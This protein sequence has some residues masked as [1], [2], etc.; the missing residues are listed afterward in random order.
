MDAA[1]KMKN[2]SAAA[3]E[4]SGTAGNKRSSDDC[5]AADNTDCCAAA[6]KQQQQQDPTADSYAI[7][8]AD[9][10]AER[11]E[12]QA[13]QQAQGQQAP[14]AVQV[15]YAAVK[16]MDKTSKTPAG[17][18]WL[19]EFVSRMEI[20]ADGSFRLSGDK[21]QRAFDYDKGDWSGARNPCDFLEASLADKGKS[22][23]DEAVH[24]AARMEAARLHFEDKGRRWAHRGTS[25]NGKWYRG[26]PVGCS[27]SWSY[28]DAPFAPALG[29]SA[30]D[31][32]WTETKVDTDRWALD[33]QGKLVPQAAAAAGEDGASAAGAAGQAPTT[34]VMPVGCYLLLGNQVATRLEEKKNTYFVHL[35]GY[36]HYLGPQY[37]KE[38]RDMLLNLQ[39][40]HLRAYAAMAEAANPQKKRSKRAAA[41]PA[42]RA[43]VAANSTTAA[44]GDD[45]D[46]AATLLLRRK[47]LQADADAAAAGAA[48]AGGSVRLADFAFC[49]AAVRRCLDTTTASSCGMAAASTATSTSFLNVKTEEGLASLPVGKLGSG[50]GSG[51]GGSISGTMILA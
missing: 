28:T 30:R 41:A 4:V 15:E 23:E 2:N 22:G 9:K 17:A 43:A 27:H 24:H 42:K 37:D 20:G 13:Q 29:L 38:R 5:A 8:G 34:P 40:S 47:Q 50:S 45:A 39:L 51:S 14:L 25:F 21:Y 11:D 10:L 7:Y 12:Q 46:T 3:A 31:V 35:R 16:A 33:V 49:K 1:G 6:T 36:M 48:A 18:R 19:W 26:M 32:R 44:A